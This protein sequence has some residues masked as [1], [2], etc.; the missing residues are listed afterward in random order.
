M[1]KSF[2]FIV[3]AAIVVVAAAFSPLGQENAGSSD[4]PTALY[5]RQTEGGTAVRTAVTGAVA[6]GKLWPKQD[7]SLGFAG[8]GV[9]EAVYFKEGD[10]VRQGDVL[11]EI[12]G[13]ENYRQQY[14]EAELNL[15]AARDELKALNDG[16]PL[17]KADV[18][19][20]LVEARRALDDADVI[21]AKGQGNYE[22][23]TGQGRHIFYAFLCKCDLFTTRF[24]VP[25]LTGMLV[26]EKGK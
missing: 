11:A 13:S 25:P 6:E 26:E 4:G 1:K 3:L 23:L 22:S 14:A 8:A 24:R 12:K 15:A 19:R 21:L 17:E 10:T 2:V 5:V 7:V 18:T 16:Y 20:R 9:V